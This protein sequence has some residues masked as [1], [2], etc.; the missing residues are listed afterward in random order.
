MLSLVDLKR[1]RALEDAVHGR[2][3]PKKGKESELEEYLNELLEILDEA[4]ANFKDIRPLMHSFEMMIE[5]ID[6][7]HLARE[8]WAK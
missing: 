3:K 2:R 5:Y 1:D 6:D 7:F 4:E 8:E